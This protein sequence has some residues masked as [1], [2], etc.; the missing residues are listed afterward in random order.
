MAST[1]KGSKL[2]KLVK[3]PIRVLIKLR[4]LYVN[5]L[6]ECSDRI[7]HDTIMG[8]PTAQAMNTLPRSFSVSSTKS[9]SSRKDDDFKE[10]IRAASTRSLGDKVELDLLRRQQTSTIIRKQPNMINNN[11]PRSRSVFVAR[12]DEDKSMDFGDDEHVKV[13][14]GVFQRSRSSAVSRKIGVLP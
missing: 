11:M 2:T 4:D 6:I 5:S 1:K 7:S 9:S 14:T 8:C 10:L 12:I 3:A 13:N